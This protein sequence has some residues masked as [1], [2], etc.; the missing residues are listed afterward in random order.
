MSG[1]KRAPV[2]SRGLVLRFAGYIAHLLN[3]CDDAGTVGVQAF[4]VYRTIMAALE[5]RESAS[6]T[7]RYDVLVGRKLLGPNVAADEAAEAYF[8]QVLER[9]LWLARD[10]HVH[11]GHELFLALCRRG[12]GDVWRTAELRRGHPRGLP[13][14]GD[15]SADVRGVFDR[16]AN[17]GC[18]LSDGNPAKSTRAL[19]GPL[20]LHVAEHAAP[21]PEEMS[22]WAAICCAPL[23]L[24]ALERGPEFHAFCSVVIKAVEAANAHYGALLS[25]GLSPRDWRD[26]SL[27]TAKKTSAFLSKVRELARLTGRTPRA[28]AVWQ[29]V[30][31][32]QHVPGYS[33]AEEFRG[34][35][36]GQALLAPQAPIWVDDA[37]DDLAVPSREEHVLDAVSFERMLELAEKAGIVRSCEVRVLMGLYL[38]QTTMEQIANGAVCRDLIGDVALPSRRAVAEHL[39]KLVARI[40]AHAEKPDDALPEAR[41]PGA[42]PK[43]MARDELPAE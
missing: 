13:A 21:V 18:G 5:A 1:E 22:V 37:I 10:Q 26:L 36:L 11:K 15:L 27:N 23:R 3:E 29:E 43:M 40:R 9:P 6:Q 42:I 20:Q 41:K 30:W 12:L 8:E 33:S 16:L 2:S 39:R 34:S 28:L 24:R 38:E 4:S 31:P 25:L 17:M 7:G 19:H 32:Q 14:G 35:E